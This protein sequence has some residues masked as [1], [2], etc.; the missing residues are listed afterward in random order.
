MSKSKNCRLFIKQNPVTQKLNFQTQ[1]LGGGDS[2][3]TV[4]CLMSG[5]VLYTRFFSSKSKVNVK[6][7]AEIAWE[8]LRRDGSV[9]QADTFIANEA[10]EA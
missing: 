7:A 8:V 4:I 9:D 3:A 10:T 5:L 6:Q 1:D 2:R